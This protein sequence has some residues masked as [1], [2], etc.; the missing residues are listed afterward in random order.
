[1]V[2]GM[3]EKNIKID[4]IGM[5]SHHRT[6]DTDAASRETVDKTIKKFAALGLQ[7]HI[8]ELDVKTVD[9]SEEEL[10]K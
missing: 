5:Q 2:K 3:Q 8:T 6:T 1:M 4:G 9:D 10:Q 7:V